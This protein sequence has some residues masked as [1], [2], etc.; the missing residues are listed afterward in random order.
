MLWGD[1]G[2]D[3]FE[4]VVGQPGA[5]PVFI[6]DLFGDGS[7]ADRVVF[8]NADGSFLTSGEVSGGNLTIVA[9]GSNSLLQIGGETVAIVTGVAPA[10]LTGDDA[11]IANLAL[12]GLTPLS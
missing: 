11:W 9:D 1:D 6:R 12:N 4:V 3:V 8:S 10:T 2:I 7:E 5:D